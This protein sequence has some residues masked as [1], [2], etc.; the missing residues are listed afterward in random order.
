MMC[1]ICGE[2]YGFV[3][4][5]ITQKHKITTRE[6]KIKFGLDVTMPLMDS[7]IVEKKRR[8]FFN[9]PTYSNLEKGASHRF[10]KGSVTRTYFSKSFREY[11]HN[12]GK[13]PYN[14]RIQKNK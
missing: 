14:F 3:G 1:K 2:N 6:Y 8:A 7:D 11:M 5:H 13:Q 12:M 10:K 9:N 4:I